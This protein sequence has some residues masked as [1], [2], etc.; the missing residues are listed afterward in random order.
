MPTAYEIDA[1]MKLDTKDFTKEM[2]K[3]GKEAEDFSE[4]LSDTTEEAKGLGSQLSGFSDMVIKGLAGL[5]AISTIKN[6]ANQFWDLA[7]GAAASLDAVDKNS[8]HLGWSTQAYQEWSYVFGQNGAD[9]DSAERAI[10]KMNSDITEFR[11]SSPDTRKAYKELGLSMKELATMTPEERFKAVVSAFQDMPD[12]AKKAQLGMEIFGNASADLMPLLNSTTEDTNALRDAAHSMGGV[13]SD[14]AVKAG[15][16]FGD[17]TDDLNFSVNAMKTNIG[18]AAIGFFQ[19]LVES[20]TD[21]VNN[22]NDYFFGDGGLDHQFKKIVK[23]YYQEVAEVEAT[24][25]EASGLVEL[26][27]RI[28]NGEIEGEEEG[29]SLWMQTLNE[30]EKKIPG[31][32]SIVDEETGK[33]QGGTQALRDYVEQYKETQA[34]M[35]RLKA[36]ESRQ[37]ALD[38][39]QAQITADQADLMMAQALSDAYHRALEEKGFDFAGAFAW[40]AFTGREYKPTDPMMAELVEGYRESTVKAQQLSK[41][42]EDERAE[43][44]KAQAEYDIFSKMLTGDDATGVVEE[45]VESK[46]GDLSAAA[47]A[48]DADLTAAAEDVTALGEEADEAK[49][50][51]DD[52]TAALEALDGKTVKA[53]VNVE[54]NQPGMSGSA[55]SH[56]GDWWMDKREYA[57]GLPYVP[58]DEY[59][60]S[61]HEGEAVLTKAQAEEWRSKRDSQTHAIEPLDYAKLGAAVANALASVEITL[62][63]KA[64]TDHVSRGIA[65]RSRQRRYTG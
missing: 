33:I 36:L 14:E 38:N 18:L 61:L 50:L 41:Q 58:Y 39:A 7:G 13:F 31:V 44:E 51:V 10:N 27:D 12:G 54:I 6:V 65:A 42:V 17:A 29:G 21:M 26:L 2:Q 59:A 4:Q 64:I 63:G 46:I 47:E 15:A 34:E 19:P 48:G 9:I 55:Y 25:V 52:L 23:N 3:A 24:A 53:S 11:K 22:V 20:A 30:L 8:Q 32:A 57:T 35:A 28:A 62:D 45:Y 37:T 49:T 1:K 40:E 43:L 5:G 56:A 16:A 60:A